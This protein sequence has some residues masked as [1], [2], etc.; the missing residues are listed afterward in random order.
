MQQRNGVPCSG[1]PNESS[2]KSCACTVLNYLIDTMGIKCN[3][4][5]L[6]DNVIG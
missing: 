4:I 2:V 3:R 1:T 6:W 5:V